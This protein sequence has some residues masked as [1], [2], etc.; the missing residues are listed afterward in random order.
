MKPSGGDIRSAL[1]RDR[2]A[3]REIFLQPKPTLRVLISA[4]CVRC[5]THPPTKL[6]KLYSALTLLCTS[7]S[8]AQ[9][10]PPTPAGPPPTQPSRFPQNGPPA[11]APNGPDKDAGD[12]SGRPFVDMMRQRFESKGGGMDQLN[13]ED[14]K[15]LRTVMEKVWNK[16]EVKSARDAAADAAKKY[17]DVMHE[18][19]IKEDPSLAPLLEKI[20]A[21]MERMPMGGPGGPGFSPSQPGQPRQPN[22]GGP[23][24]GPPNGP[25]GPGAGPAGGGPGAVPEAPSPRQA[26]RGEG[27]RGGEGGRGE[28]SMKLFGLESSELQKLPED[29]RGRLREAFEKI[30]QHPEVKAAREA[31]EQAEGEGKREAFRKMR[32]VVKTV[33]EKE[34]PELAKIVERLRSQAGPGREGREGRPPLEESAPTPPPARGEAPPANTPGAPENAPPK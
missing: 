3:G 34:Y 20:K 16:D 31:A 22:P 24:Q 32:D 25:G 13:E 11:G 2:R 18:A 26:G 28:G 19:A 12:R 23:P 7:F 15:R 30:M 5:R 29:Q 9:T 33:A 10:P 6:M 27:T 14:R 4:P 17:R 8:L 1:E 21:N